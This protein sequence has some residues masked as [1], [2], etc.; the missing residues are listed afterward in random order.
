[1][2]QSCDA[3]KLTRQVCPGDEAHCNGGAHC[4]SQYS[5]CAAASSSDD[6]VNLCCVCRQP[7]RSVMHN[8]IDIDASHDEHETYLIEDIYDNP[9][10]HTEWHQCVTCDVTFRRKSVTIC[11][12]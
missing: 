11:Q 9:V 3:C 7:I 2:T 5:E 6:H 1:M 12:D 10:E 4:T 8:V